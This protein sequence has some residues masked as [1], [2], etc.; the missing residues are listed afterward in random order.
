MLID[1]ESIISVR[2][3]FVPFSNLAAIT[4]CTCILN[5]NIHRIRVNVEKAR[6]TY[7]FHIIYFRFLSL[8]SEEIP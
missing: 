6:N 4:T 3:K 5:I 7:Y 2:F 1:R 8:R